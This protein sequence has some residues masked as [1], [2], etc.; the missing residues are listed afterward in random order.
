MPLGVTL[1][2][3]LPS[4]G[5]K[6]GPGPSS[7]IPPSGNGGYQPGPPSPWYLD[8]S[9]PVNPIYT[10]PGSNVLANQYDAWLKAQQQQSATNRNTDVTLA[11]SVNNVNNK[12]L[13]NSTQN[14]LNLNNEARFRNSLDQQGVDIQNAQIQA[15]WGVT[16][17]QFMQ[18]Q[19]YISGVWGR[20]NAANQADNAYFNQRETNTRLGY[21]F[22]DTEQSLANQRA[23]LQRDVNNRGA[24]S[25]ATSRGAAVSQGFSDNLNTIESQ[26]SL[27]QQAA[28]STRDQQYANVSQSI[29]DNRNSQRIGNEQWA[30]KSASLNK[31]E[32]DTVNAYK[33]RT[34]DMQA[35]LDQNGVAKDALASVAREYGLKDKDLLD[36]LGSAIEKNN[37]N[38]SQ[39]IQN[40]TEAYQ[41]KD[42][43]QIAQM[44]QFLAQLMG[45]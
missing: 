38:L 44:N 18:D 1:P 25:D 4:Y 3:A 35:Q 39:V 30:D 33:Q 34:I 19:A 41:S 37:L 11:N 13:V 15:Q 10:N 9:K 28:Q 17:D 23:Q 26:L 22:A 5:P 32:T 2:S 42:A 45:A 24:F 7:S 20:G 14:Q 8:Q 12:S 29:F 27:A 31:S 43:N 6:K 16:N 36:S 21:G 40:I